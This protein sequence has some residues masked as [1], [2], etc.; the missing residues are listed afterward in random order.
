MYVNTC[1]LMYV[2]LYVNNILTKYKYISS[3]ILKQ[4]QPTLITLDNITVI[5]VSLIGSNT[6]RLYII[7]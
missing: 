6:L 3:I 1:S 4:L 7:R 2:N 5:G